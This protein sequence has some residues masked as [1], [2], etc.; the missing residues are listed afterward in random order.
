M[1]HARVAAQETPT[2]R[3]PMPVVQTQYRVQTSFEREQRF[4]GLVQAASRS[5]I[6]FEV[7]GAIARI[8]VHE[9]Q[10]VAAGDPLASL[11][12][13]ALA[14]R[15][16]AA[17]FA[18]ERAR[19]ELELATARTTRQAP[20][21]QSGAISAQLFDDTRLAEKAIASALA[22]AQSQLD[23]LDIDLEKSVLRAPYAARIGRQ[24]LDRGAVTQPGTPV[25][26][27][28]SIAEREA[29]IGVAV[30][31][32]QYLET[33]R[34]YPLQWRGQ[35]MEA[36]LLAVRPDVNPISM[37]TVAIFSV[38][39]EL[40]AFDGEPV[41]VS[42]PRTEPEAGGWLPLS[43]LIEGEQGIW[44]VLALRERKGGTVALREAVE[45]LHVSGNR[46]YVRGS[47]NDGDRVIADGVHRIAP[48]TLVAPLALSSV[49]VSEL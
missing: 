12:T 27:L 37:T 10:A 9:G 35:A 25:F 3:A 28:T 36:T 1:L 14:A 5:Q 26:A 30:E 2:T 31:Q 47:V 24:L 7:P 11:D 8:H 4:L 38:T 39:A 44:T 34:T 41:S 33:G 48:G 16:D 23:A 45:V 19:A 42:L 20:L 15:R 46:A 32:A 13:Q 21:V 29:H 17:A 49:V 6:G 22:A 18:V 40:E 43:S